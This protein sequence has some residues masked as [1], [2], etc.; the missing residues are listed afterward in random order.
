MR[1]GVIECAQGE[2]NRMTKDSQKRSTQLKKLT[3]QNSNPQKSK[4][5]ASSR[6]ECTVPKWEILILWW[7]FLGSRGIGVAFGVMSAKVVVVTCSSLLCSPPVQRGVWVLVG[8][9]DKED[10]TW[11][12]CQKTRVS[13]LHPVKLSV[14]PLRVRTPDSSC[15]VAL[16][17]QHGVGLTESRPRGIVL[18]HVEHDF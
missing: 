8:S 3:K 17:V 1:E 15:G 4:A 5:I 2:N 12:V 9:V 6:R 11:S 18:R 14:L 10:S 13:S 16:C 7:I